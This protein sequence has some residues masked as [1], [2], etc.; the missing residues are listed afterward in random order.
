[1]IDWVDFCIGLAVGL[2][3]ATLV[4]LFVRGRRG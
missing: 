3:I 4:S 1:M 2:G